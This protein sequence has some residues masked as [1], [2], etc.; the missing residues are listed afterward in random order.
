MLLYTG[1]IMWN[2]VC[3]RL[4]WGGLFVDSFLEDLNLLWPKAIEQ[5]K[6]DQS[7]PI[8]FV[9][10]LSLTGHTFPRSIPPAYGPRVHT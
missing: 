5:R 8:K 10:H 7:V 4:P 1:M 2:S 3:Q 9:Q 6:K